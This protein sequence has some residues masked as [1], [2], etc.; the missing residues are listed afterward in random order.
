MNEISDKYNDAILQEAIDEGYLV[1]GGEN[2]EDS[3]TTKGIVYLKLSPPNGILKDLLLGVLD[4]RVQTHG[5]KAGYL[6]HTPEGKKISKRGEVYL[7]S[8]QVDDVELIF[9]K[10]MP[11]IAELADRLGVYELPEKEQGPALDG[12]WDLAFKHFLAE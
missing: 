7:R 9:A 4:E 12:I 10:V 11:K 2:G 5:V 8:M 3:V 6:E 1:L